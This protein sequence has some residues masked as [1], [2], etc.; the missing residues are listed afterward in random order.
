MNRRLR[1]LPSQSCCLRGV[2]SQKPIKAASRSRQT[3]GIW[4]WIAR[5]SR[6]SQMMKV[7]KRVMVHL[8]YSRI[9]WFLH[10]LVVGSTMSFKIKSCLQP[11]NQFLHPLLLL[12]FFRL[13]SMNTH[14]SR[15][16]PN[17]IWTR[18]STCSCMVKSRC[19][20]SWR[21]ITI[22]TMTKTNVKAPRGRTKRIYTQTTARKR[23]GISTCADSVFRRLT[24]K[25]RIS[26]GWWWALMMMT[27]SATERTLLHIM[28]SHL[29]IIYQVLR[30]MSNS[31]WRQ[32][33][34][35]NAFSTVSSVCRSLLTH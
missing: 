31:I 15:S 28:K 18:T 12:N 13:N 30:N 21:T 22:L 17:P 26:S 29:L 6:N 35:K 11:M 16:N 7:I 20:T 27:K 34:T 3:C 23:L 33:F 9:W 2:W 1:S 19:S 10:L 24:R 25:S 4:I 32:D 5:M 14:N 8:L